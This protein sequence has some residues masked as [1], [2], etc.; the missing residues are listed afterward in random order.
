MKRDRFLVKSFG[1]NIEGTKTGFI[2]L[3]QILEEYTNA[4]VVVPNL[5]NIKYTM[6]VDVLGEA[7]SNQ[8]IKNRKIILTD[9]KI[10]TLCSESTIIDCK[11]ADVYL[12]LW[13][14][15]R[16]IQ[17]IEALPQWKSMIL[18]TWHPTDSEQWEKEN[19][20]MIIYDDKKK[21]PYSRS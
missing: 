17:F 9:N 5:G 19:N 3:L 15:N 7:L 16:N 13:G 18:V 12:V 1:D 2:K 4:V 21:K 8:L 14:T 6:I 11:Y 10:I 20:V